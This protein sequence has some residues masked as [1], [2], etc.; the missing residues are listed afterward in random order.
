MQK[1]ADRRHHAVLEMIEKL[2]EATLSERASMVINSAWFYGS[3]PTLLQI[4][5]HHSW[6]SNRCSIHFD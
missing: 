6:F 3:P 2:S 1:D 5:G 4:S